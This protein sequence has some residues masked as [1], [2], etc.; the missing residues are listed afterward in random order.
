MSDEYVSKK[1]APWE[2]S[3][4]ADTPNWIQ[5][6]GVDQPMEDSSNYSGP[7][8]FRFWMPSG[9]SK[10]VI[11][12]T[13]GTG[14]DGPPGVFE[15]NIPLGSGKGRWQNWFS[16]LEPLGMPCPLCQYSEMREGVGRRYKGMFFT[17]IDCSQYTDRQG[18]KQKNTKKLL[19]AKRD[20]V[21]MLGRKASSREDA[22][23]SLRGAM[24]KIHRNAGDNSRSVGDD[25]EFLKMV[26]LSTL[27]DSEQF[28]YVELL[29]PDPDKVTQAFERWKRESEQFGNAGDFNSSSEGT[30]AQIKY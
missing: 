2:S 23:E 25:F 16:C 22:G 10:G 1:G 20:T 17:V 18:R 24:Y 7:K 29:K 3:N 5:G 21:E 15:H 13:A 26:D 14:A 11:F 27:E 4:T 12:L 8:V 28:D 6:T 19:C 30:S 9:S